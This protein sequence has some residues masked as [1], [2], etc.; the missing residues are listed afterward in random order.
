MRFP[1]LLSSASASGVFFLLLLLFGVSV[2]LPSPRVRHG[3]HVFRTFHTGNLTRA[4]RRLHEV[5]AEISGIPLEDHILVVDGTPFMEEQLRACNIS[6]VFGRLKPGAYRSDLL[7]YCLLYL[8]GGIY[9]DLMVQFTRRVLGV[10]RYGLSVVED[11]RRSALWNG[12]MAGRRGHP[13]FRLAMDLVRVNVEGCVRG[14]S[15]LYP[16][17]PEL[18]YRA[19]SGFDRMVLGRVSSDNGRCSGCVKADGLFINK[20]PS[21]WKEFRAMGYGKYGH[22]HKMWHTYNIYRHCKL[23][24]FAEF[25]WL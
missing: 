16:T 13:A 11:R 15:P 25:F 3:R 19:A 9:V 24:D 23:Y 20:M 12:F 8:H 10:F 17:G 1:V 4:V 7:R 18:W 21:Y 22:Y 5:S 2:C 6:D 14:R